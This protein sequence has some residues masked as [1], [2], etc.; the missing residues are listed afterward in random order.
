MLPLPPETLPLLR[1]S[2]HNN[3][4]EDERPRGG[5]KVIQPPEDQ[6]GQPSGFNRRTG[7]VNQDNEHFSQFSSVAQSCLTLC[8][9]MD[10]STSG[11]L[12]RHFL[13]ESTQ[14]HVH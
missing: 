14:T 7:R 13:P 9:P 5:G 11:L 3:L 1:E 8:D 12:V 6:P 2:A 4:Q 10:C